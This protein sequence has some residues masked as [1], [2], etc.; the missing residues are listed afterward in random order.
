LTVQL[1]GLPAVPGLGQHG[2]PGS[3]SRITRKPRRTIRWSSAITT[4]TSRS[5]SA[6]AAAPVLAD[7]A[8]LPA[9]LA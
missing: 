7:S 9:G 3:A 8:V 4:V 6:L 5:A 2:D 1:D